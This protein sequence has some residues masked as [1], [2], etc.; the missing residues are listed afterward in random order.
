MTL[1]PQPGTRSRR[2]HRSPPHP[3]MPHSAEARLSET[4]SCLRC[5]RP[6]RSQA[7]KK[8]H[9]KKEPRNTRNP[10][11]GRFSFRV[12]RVFRGYHSGW[13]FAALR[14]SRLCVVIASPNR[15][16]G[17]SIPSVTLPTLHAPIAASPPRFSAP[18][19]R[20]F[21]LTFC[22]VL[23][24]T[25]SASIAPAFPPSGWCNFALHRPSGAHLILQLPAWR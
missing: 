19:L 24:I 14:S 8:S 16:A 2:P 20:H 21:C 15:P 1:A 25:P 17:P 3:D 10:E 5:N 22:P 9:R 6:I 12:F 11:P 18:F 7:A 13:A 23:L 4:I